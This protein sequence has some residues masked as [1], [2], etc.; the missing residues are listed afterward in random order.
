MEEDMTRDCLQDVEC[1]A[2]RIGSMLQ[3]ELFANA[4]SKRYIVLL[5]G[6]GGNYRIWKNQIP[7]LQQQFNVL[8]VNL[9]SHGEN[10]IK[11]S[12][13]Q[14]SLESVS[15]EIIRVL[16]S[17]GIKKAIFM[18]LSIGTIFIKYMEMFYQSYIETAV[19]VGGIATVGLFLK[20]A[21]WTFS[22]I[23]D[24]LPFSMVYRIF[25]KILMPWKISK[26]S[27]Q[28]FGE[29]AKALNRIEFQAYMYIFKEHF[30]RAKDFIHEIHTENVYISGINDFCFLKGIKKESNATNGK[31]ITI[32][33]C[34][35]VCNIDQTKAFNEILTDVLMQKPNTEDSPITHSV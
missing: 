33:H 25:A 14:L 16:D 29:C 15:Q 20:L 27:R 13:M 34:G 24:K 12:E 23:G 32:Q 7:I 8:A 9:P 31:L 1:V 35:H 21:V 11:L 6:F 3:Y 5:H 10:K 18:G 30:Q 22:K 26:R 4:K 28:V 2:V 17:L 19:L